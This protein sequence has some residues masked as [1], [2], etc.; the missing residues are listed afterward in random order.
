MVFFKAVV[1]PS[2]CH[3]NRN[4]GLKARAFVIYIRCTYTRFRS[5]AHDSIRIT[6]SVK[7]LCSPSTLK[8]LK[9]LIGHWS[10]IFI[11]NLRGGIK[12]MSFSENKACHFEFP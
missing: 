5:V 12:K 6:S 1:R 9:G 3:A 7:Q 11:G 8:G 10:V 2:F 4:F